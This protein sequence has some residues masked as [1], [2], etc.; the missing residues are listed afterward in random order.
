VTA[1]V[2]CLGKDKLPADV[3]Q[4]VAKRGKGNGRPLHA[5]KCGHCGHWHVGSNV[6]RKPDANRRRM[7]RGGGR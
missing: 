2:E 6:A 5:Y 3:A 7:K 4:R 1:E